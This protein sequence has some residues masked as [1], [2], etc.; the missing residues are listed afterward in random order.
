MDIPR[1]NT[2]MKQ[3]MR[4][5]SVVQAKAMDR[6]PVQETKSRH[7]VDT[8]NRSDMVQPDKQSPKIS[9]EEL[10]AMLSQVEEHFANN[11]VKLK[12]NVLEE[13]GTVQVEIIDSDGKTIRKIPDD[14]LLKLTESLKNIGK[15]F[16]DKVS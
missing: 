16:L 11:N 10:N 1:I 13:N 15:G 6:P 12:F 4:S 3:D 9:E 14:D 7:P 2:D 5:E 8:V